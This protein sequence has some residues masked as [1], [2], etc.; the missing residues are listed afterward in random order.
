LAIATYKD[1]FI[2]VGYI[3]AAAFVKSVYSSNIVIVLVHYE[4]SATHLLSGQKRYVDTALFSPNV[5]VALR[6]ETQKGLDC[7]VVWH[8]APDI[9]N[10]FSRTIVLLM[11][12]TQNTQFFAYIPSISGPKIKVSQVRKTSSNIRVSTN[13]FGMLLM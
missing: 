2:R 4:V 11:R 9:N 10:S 3:N 13:P 5:D 6:V 8:F 1:R 12:L 7:F